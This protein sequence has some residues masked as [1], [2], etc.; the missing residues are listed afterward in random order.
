M[1]TGEDPLW[2]RRAAAA[3][4]SFLAGGIHVVAAP[5]H[6]AEWWGYGVF[7]FFAAAAQ[8][9]Y[10]ILL[11]LEPWKH[12][13]GTVR[14]DWPRRARGAYGAGIV[15]NVL[16]VLLYLQSRTL[17]VPFGPEAGEVEPVT[18]IGIAS[19][20]TEVLLVCALWDLRKRTAP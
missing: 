19:K 5:E 14:P 18:P 7:F 4:L 12:A 16:V 8:G 20:V 3:V 17:G 11:V 1:E 6:A 10:A 9:F 15:G 2:T 13:G